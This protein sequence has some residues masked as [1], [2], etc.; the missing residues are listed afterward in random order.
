MRKAYAFGEQRLELS[1][2]CS[3]ASADKVPVNKVGKVTL[4]AAPSKTSNHT[5]G[6][7]SSDL[8]TQSRLDGTESEQGESGVCE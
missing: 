3:V 8:C 6:R 2:G 4:L 1:V 7:A 5:C